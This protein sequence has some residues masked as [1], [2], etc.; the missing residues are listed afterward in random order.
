MR[1]TLVD[2]GWLVA[3]AETFWGEI[4]RCDHVLQIYDND[5]VFLDTLTGFVQA[6]I[7]ADENAVVVAT[8]T[9]LN[10]LEARLRAYGFDIEMLISHNRF[11]PLNVDDIVIELM[12]NGKVNESVL[13]NLRSS[14]VQMPGYDQRKLRMFGELSPTLLA[15]GWK[16][17]ALR[18]EQLAD[19]N[20]HENPA[21]IF[22]AY[23]KE[24][25]NRKTTDL[26][27][28]ICHAH[29]KMISGSAKQLTHVFYKPILSMN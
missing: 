13:S 8:E 22:C 18:L 19:Q 14:F 16:E 10:A 1:Q 27:T 21:C 9:H 25:L 23:P 5:G 29:S 17:S 15:H 3:N 12:D 2:D 6:A 11:I 20:N 4:A 28:N 26:T 24:L 7:K